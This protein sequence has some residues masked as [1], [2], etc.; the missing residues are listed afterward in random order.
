MQ[1]SDP[2][3]T[4]KNRTAFT[5]TLTPEEHSQAQEAAVRTLGQSVNLPGFRPGKAPADMVK[6]RLKPEAILEEVIRSVVPT[7]V[8]QITDAHTL[9]PVIP[10]HVTVETV[11]PLV[12]TIT[13]V[14][15]PQV[16]VKGAKALSVPKEAVKVDE[17]DV[18]RTV[19]YVLEQHRT[20]QTVDRAAQQGDE[21]TMDFSGTDEAGTVIPGTESTGYRVR[22]GSQ[23]LIPG[24]EEQLVGL[25]ANGEKKFTVTFPENYHAEHLRGKPA[26]FSVKVTKVEEVILPEL[27]DAFAKQELRA[28]SAADFRKRVEDSMR[29]QEERLNRQ[30][31]EEK[32]L[33]MIIDATEVDL[34]EE[35]V[36]REANQ[37]GGELMQQLQEQN[38]SLDDWL[39]ETQR[40]R[41]S[42]DEELRKEATRRLTLRYGLEAVIAERG[43]TVT[44]EE[45]QQAVQELLQDVPENERTDAA[46]QYTPGSRAYE[47][48]TWRRTVMKFLEE[49][50]T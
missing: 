25:G 17:K 24:F 15:K 36:D 19:D 21:V 50:L 44:P 37:I 30:K 47:E 48:L 22:I 26:T 31:Q 6:G 2:R 38:M 33:Q 16:K 11:D 29:Q 41:Q 42:F 34:A 27:T 13:F 40:T 12:L 46:A 3:S 7:A 39:T 10:P 28:D 1:I 18:Q 4:G 9:A 35:L 23:T 8:K 45:V 43:I 49:A 32:L 20:T 14:E 5:A